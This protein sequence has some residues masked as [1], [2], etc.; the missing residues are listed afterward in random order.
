MSESY[1]NQ[2][3]DEKIIC[4]YCGR[5]YEPTYDET[6]IGDKAADCFTEYETQTFTC[7][8]CGKKFTMTPHMSRWSYE[9]ETID[10]EMTDDE[11]EN[12]YCKQ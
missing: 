2:E 10:G 6:Y 1:W 9:T 4:P 7:D 12:E 11:W 3:D 5:T 8:G